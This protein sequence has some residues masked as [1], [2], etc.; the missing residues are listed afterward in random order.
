M[1]I[2]T[3]TLLGDYADTL[4][5]HLPRFGIR[6]DDVQALLRDLIAGQAKEPSATVSPLQ[7]ASRRK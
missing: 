6:A 7:P 2:Q 5:R 4:S 3:Q 1:Q